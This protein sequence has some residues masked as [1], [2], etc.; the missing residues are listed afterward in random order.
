MPVIYFND[1]FNNATNFTGLPIAYGQVLLSNRNGTPSDVL[2]NIYQNPLF[3]ATNDF[4]LSSSSPCANAGSPNSAY[5]NMC[6]PPSIATN[7]PDQGA[8]GGPDACNWLSVVPVLP[9]SAA[10][11]IDTNNVVSMSLGAIPRSTYQ[12]QFATNLPSTNW[13][14]LTNGLVIAPQRPTSVV[15]ATNPTAPQQ[16]F[17]AQSLGRTPGN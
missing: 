12:L 1:F 10:M 15:I 2:Y 8:Y 13:M 14:N 3:I 7:Y 16:Y 4:H 9:I 17:R 6:F 5:A 11:S